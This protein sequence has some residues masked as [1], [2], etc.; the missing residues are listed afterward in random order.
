MYNNLSELRHAVRGTI[1]ALN[2]CV[3]A[4]DLPSETSEK[5]EFLNDIECAAEK[6]AE[7][8]A[9]LDALPPAALLQHEELVGSATARHVR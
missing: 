6:L 2:L 9:E 5:L 3:T 8:C 4:F 7:L 1:N